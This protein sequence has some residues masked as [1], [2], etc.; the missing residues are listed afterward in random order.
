VARGSFQFSRILML[1]VFFY[2]RKKKDGD[3]AITIDDKCE[4]AYLRRGVALFNK[5]EYQLVFEDVFFFS[6]VKINFW[7]FLF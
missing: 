1:R 4:M 7:F 2:F 5:K 6:F 3:Q